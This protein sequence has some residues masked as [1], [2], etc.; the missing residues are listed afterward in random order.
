MTLAELLRDAYAWAD[1]NAMWVL[2]GGVTVPVAGTIAAR[3][4]KAG[5]TDADGKLIASLVMGLALMAVVLEV[6]CLFIARSA[7]GA[8]LLQANPLLLVAPVVC[9]AGAVVGLRLVFPLTELGSVRT[10]I[11][12]GAFLLA[13]AGVVWLASKF[14]WGVLFIGS[15]GQLVVILAL[16]ALVLRRMYR[17]AFGIDSAR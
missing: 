12:L 4:G 8:D 2:L 9:L 13:C 3:I 6:A 7:L 11:D 10:A 5:K 1:T 15:I 17:R 14:R 16:A